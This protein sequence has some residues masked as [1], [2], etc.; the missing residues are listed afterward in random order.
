MMIGKTNAISSSGAELNAVIE[1]GFT[2]ATITAVSPANIST[3]SGNGFT[4]S[5]DDTAVVKST[6]FPQSSDSLESTDFTLIGS[7]GKTIS[8]SIGGPFNKGLIMNS[9]FISS[10]I[11]SLINAVTTVNITGPIVND[12]VNLEITD[13]KFR[14]ILNIVDTT[15]NKKCTAFLDV[16]LTISITKDSYTLIPN[17]S[18]RISSGTNALTINQGDQLEISL[19][20]VGIY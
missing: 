11:D 6:I 1:I 3:T 4:H 13:P 2:P 7:S 14:L 16:T 20:D 5:S 9:T 10:F 17:A 15:S 18:G 12:I 19:I 8:V